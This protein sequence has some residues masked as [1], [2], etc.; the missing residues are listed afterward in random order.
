MNKK[1]WLLVPLALLLGAAI[2]PY[3]G[4]EITIRLNEPTSFHLN[5]ANYSNLIFY[6]LIY[7]NFFYLKK[8]GEISSNVFQ[9]YRYD[10]TGKTLLLTV[11]DTL[12]SANGKDLTAKN[13]PV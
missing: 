10:P 11:R 6:S 1:R 9:E 8:T 13:I 3:Y 7:E 2:K 5:T 4:G 12:S